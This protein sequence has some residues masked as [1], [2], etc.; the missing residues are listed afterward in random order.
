MARRRFPLEPPN[1]HRRK[2]LGGGKYSGGDKA[3]NQEDGVLVEC[4]VLLQKLKGEGAGARGQGH[5]LNFCAKLRAVCH[6]LTNP[7]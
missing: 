5:E 7:G 6:V 2:T 1:R 4:G 3:G